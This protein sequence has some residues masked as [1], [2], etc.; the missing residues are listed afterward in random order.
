MYNQDKSIAFPHEYVFVENP[1][2]T[3]QYVEMPENATLL[4]DLFTLEEL[5]ESR[6]R[7]RR[8][9]K[10]AK[11]SSGNH[12]RYWVKGHWRKRRTKKKMATVKNKK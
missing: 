2:N 8:R 3:V 10:R 1:E 11:G 5:I 9:K 6:S 4:G 7:G 12:H